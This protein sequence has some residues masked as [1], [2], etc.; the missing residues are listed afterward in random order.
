MF[1]SVAILGSFCEKLSVDI[2]AMRDFHN[3]K[4]GAAQTHCVYH[5]IPAQ[6]QPPALPAGYHL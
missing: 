2:F 6:P 4:L 1:L 5:A 3:K